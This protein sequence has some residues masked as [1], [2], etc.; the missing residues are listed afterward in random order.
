MPLLPCHASFPERGRT[1][2][3]AC[4]SAFS[5]VGELSSSPTGMCPAGEIG[6]YLNCLKEL[7]H[8]T[9]TVTPIMK[10]WG[11]HT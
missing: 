3:T 1:F 6:R 2:D 9:C 5:G 7:A 10:R 4:M 8:D 11:G